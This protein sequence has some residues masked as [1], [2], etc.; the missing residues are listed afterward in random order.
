[1]LLGLIVAAMLPLVALQAWHLFA[2]ADADERAARQQALHIAQITASE[3]SRFLGQAHGI[4]RGLVARPA[5][6]AL[7]PGHCDPILREFLALSPRFSN[8]ATMRRDGEVVCSAAPLARAAR[9]DT[10]KFLD[11]LRGPGE[12]TVGLPTPGTVTGR[13]AIPVGLPLVDDQGRVA[14][15]VGLAIDLANFP[16]LPDIE[17]LPRGSVTGIIA[18]DGTILAHSKSPRQLVGS[19]HAGHA[20]VRH[21]LQERHG[22]A[23]LTSLDDM[24]GIQGFVPIPQTDWIAFAKLDAAGALDAATR[25]NRQRLATVLV[26]LGVMLVLVFLVKR[27]IELP[28]EH[29]AAVV[30]AVHAGD[31][32]RRARL[33]GPREL[34]EVAEELNTMLDAREPVEMALRR[35]E[36]RY[37]MLAEDSPDA[38]LIHQD[39]QVVF[40]NKA[41]VELMRAR[42]ASE[43]V[44]RSATAVIRPEF[45]ELARE[46]IAALYAGQSQP[47]TE[48][49][50][51]RLDGTEVP[52]EIAAAPILFEG[53]P[54]AQ[55]TV[56][57][58]SERA[59]ERALVTRQ[60]AIM[61]KI[62]A[63]ASLE[64]T[65]KAIV[66]FIEADAPDL[67]ASILLL[68]ED[69]VHVRHGAAGRLPEAYW[70]AIDGQP[71]GPKAGTCG[72][73]MHRGE[74]VVVADIATDPLWEE[75]RSVAT[76]HDLRACWSTPIFDAQRKVLG[77]FALYFHQAGRPNQRDQQLIRMATHTAAVA[78]E[79]DRAARELAMR[80]ATF[81]ATFENAAVGM[82]MTDAQGS[83]LRANPAF[84]RQLGYSAAELAGKPF[85]DFTHPDDVAE[86]ER[87][88]R[89]LMAGKMS[90]F[91]MR[92]RYVRKNGALVWIQ[93]NVSKVPSPGGGA[94]FTIGMMED[95]TAR[96]AAEEELRES[97][98]RYR[99]IL[100]TMSDGFV[101]MDRELR[102][103]YVNPR[104]EKILG[105]DAASI[106][107]RA[108]HEAFPDAAG[109]PF[110]EA[111]RRA[112]AEGATVESE[113][114]FEPWQRW[115]AQRVDPT[116]EGI[117]VFFRDTTERKK[118][119]SRIEYLATHDELTDLP[120]RNLAHDRIA[121]AISHARRSER[122]VAVLYLDLD[123]FKVINDGFGH[124]FGD[125]VLKEV[126]GRL[127]RMVREGDT[128]ARQ[129]GDEFLILL[130][131]LR[132]AGDA[133]IV[134]QKILDAF[135]EPFVLDGREV[136][137]SS[138][139]GV[140]VFPQDGQ[141]PDVLIGN[142]DVAMYRAKDL[143]RNS[144]QFFTR[145]MSDETRRRVEIETE[146]RSA[147]ARGQLQLA[148]QPKVNLATGRM[149]GCEAL[150]R[151]SHPTLGPVS[152]ARF[153]PVA[154]D[155]GL[156]VPV[157]DWVLR[158]AC[159]QARA[160]HDAGLP[161]IVVSVNLSARQ[162]LQ[163]DVVAWTLQTLEETRLA[164][165]ML[166]LELTESLIA[167]DTEKVIAT[168]NQLK[169]AGVRLSI[170]DFGTG[171]SS[172]SY[173]KRFRVDT[174]KIDQ[175]FVR[176]MLTDQDDATIVRAVIDLAHNLRLT[177]VAE[178]VETAEQRDF[179]KVNGC[180][181]MQG[182]L[183]SQPV[184]AEAFAALLK[185]AK[186][187]PPHT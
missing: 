186:E 92:K 71:I 18:A 89:A 169:A 83:L 126:G 76:A 139:L 109:S 104:A 55:V 14:G 171:Y 137:I 162:F 131:D 70:R 177:A 59:R 158:T 180:D 25:N 56:R 172:L 185:G 108:Y 51:V 16:V 156:I 163:Q 159:S 81:R 121:Q 93:L 97:E 12:L 44:G 53:R 22:T 20:M 100:E 160:W 11:I 58:I 27:R 84:C 38:I 114:Y 90:H 77:S 166:E 179:L 88:Y 32:T 13:W 69:G 82:T 157:G 150:L 86:N 147:V 117:S 95:I 133:Y 144:Y 118:N 142:A 68:D 175:S 2:A 73:A 132:R 21:I 154:E 173:L 74:Q 115:F 87:L 110:E 33:D 72:T 140:S 164:P 4:A 125:A 170:D 36:A 168:V 176:N 42:D 99:G 113:H 23:L 119:E 43:L 103:T 111:Y 78:I 39:M 174:L 161:P 138:S 91:Q 19:N 122:Q 128:V 165:G 7:D 79:K 112:L 94:P 124:P 145:E 57:D 123:R 75:Y 101:A 178:G 105:R 29:L 15:G 26:L 65:L 24:P 30:R 130:S 48:Q 52:V 181:E 37:R 28:L 1:M 151:W 31:W 66:D 98:G 49:V 187:L 8:I 63:G 67:L 127:A 54:G 85:A 120:N 182:Y 50:Y 143:G 35:S 3:T 148:Y 129:S 45:T 10:R 17:G 167:Q 5:V 136:H 183:F 149:V 41:F 61:E 64:D 40:A 152:P 107:G 153:I 9:M 141:T 134:A 135:A 60:S 96:R 155:S 47:R 46:R 102:F 6:R 106:L 146:L 62:A 80:E 116:P 34:V 184:P